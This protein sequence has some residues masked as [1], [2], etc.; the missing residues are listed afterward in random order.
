M[1]VAE[2]R[3]EIE[4]VQHWIGGRLTPSQSGRFGPVWNPATGEQQ[5]R[6]LFA[7]IE[8]VDMAV[9]TAKA[10][11][12][13]WRAGDRMRLRARQPNDRQRTPSRRG[14]LRDDRLRQIE[15]VVRS[16]TGHGVTLLAASSLREIHR[17]R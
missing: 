10:A 6:V 12:R 9:A 7:S 15:K 2:T 11:F 3:I 1:S 13:A 5:G 17:A 16:G 14:C 4:D 8:E